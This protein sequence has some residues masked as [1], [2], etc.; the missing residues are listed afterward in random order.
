MKKENRESKI[1]CTPQMKDVTYSDCATCV[2]PKKLVVANGEG[3]DGVI[4]NLLSDA[5]KQQLY[6]LRDY[7]SQRAAEIEL[8]K[9]KLEEKE[10]PLQ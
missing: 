1:Y 8:E 9:K 4:C 7:L 6:K 10:A 3:W 2:I 5:D